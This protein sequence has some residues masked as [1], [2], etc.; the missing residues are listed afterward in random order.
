MGASV[1]FFTTNN[2]RFA[3]MTSQISGSCCDSDIEPD[4]YK[5]YKSFAWE[6]NVGQQLFVV[7]EDFLSS[8]E[9]ISSLVSITYILKIF[10]GGRRGGGARQFPRARVRVQ[11]GFRGGPGGAMP[12][13]LFAGFFFL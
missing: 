2:K 1:T 13:P 5:T 11:R 12:P 9:T 4:Q 3:L 8:T 10:C 6:S 7:F